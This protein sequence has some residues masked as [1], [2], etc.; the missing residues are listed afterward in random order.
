MRRRSSLG[1]NVLVR[2]GKES[3]AFDQRNSAFFEDM[4]QYSVYTAIPFIHTS[5]QR[6][7]TCW[8]PPMQLYG[9]YG[10]LQV[11]SMNCRGYQF[12]HYRQRSGRDRL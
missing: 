9:R 5:F 7:T 8:E 2:K 12:G 10:S 3:P 11:I 1:D 6:Q 4:P